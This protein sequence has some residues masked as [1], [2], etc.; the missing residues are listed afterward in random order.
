MLIEAAPDKSIA[1]LVEKT[2]PRFLNTLT[3]T[4]TLVFKGAETQATKV[5]TV[6]EAI[7]DRFMTLCRKGRGECPGCVNKTEG[8]HHGG[9]KC[10]LR[11]SPKYNPIAYCLNL[12]NFL[13][14]GILNLKPSR[15]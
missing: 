10:Q 9:S 5:K 11:F 3:H 4:G 8:N 14:T 6:L 1:P 15:F 2:S 12:S 13:N 7:P